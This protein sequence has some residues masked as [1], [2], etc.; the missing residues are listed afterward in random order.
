MFD[1]DRIADYQQMVAKL[2]NAGIRAEMYLGTAGMK[3]Q[4]KYADRRGA[5]VVVIQGSREREQGEV[6]L[7]D[8]I[9]GEKAAAAIKDNAEWK[10]ARPAQITV[11]ESDLIPEVRKILAQYE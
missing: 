7:K 1:R 3:P 2:R 9:A 5:A 6:V 11:K 10:A 8:L 4:M